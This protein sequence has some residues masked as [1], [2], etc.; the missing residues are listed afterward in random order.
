[1][2]PTLCLAAGSTPTVLSPCLLVSVCRRRTCPMAP[3]SLEMPWQPG[4]HPRGTLR[5]TVQL[6]PEKRTL[7]G[8][9]P[10]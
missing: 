8:D 5:L 4:L 2:P 6:P 10:H 3:Q 7:G 9:W 1:M